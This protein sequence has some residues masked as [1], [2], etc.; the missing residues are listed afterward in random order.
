MHLA[1][2]M[3]RATVGTE[4]DSDLDFEGFFEAEYERLLKTMY[5]LTRNHSEAEDLAQEALAR[6]FGRWDT[7]SAAASPIA[8]VCGVAF[9]MFVIR[10]ER[11]QP[12]PG[13]LEDVPELG[14]RAPCRAVPAGL[15]RGDE[16]C[17][18]E[19]IER[20]LFL[21]GRPRMEQPSAV[22]VG[23]TVPEQL[24]SALETERQALKL[25]QEGIATALDVDDQATREFLAGRLPDEER[26]VDWLETQLFLVE[27][28]GAQLYLSE[29]LGS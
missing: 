5:V 23:A 20:V 25:L 28:L 6:A 13:A 4:R 29:Q 16:G 26:H 24:R 19:I 14:L 12:V 10:A 15:A 7:V 2:G 3:L 9:N 22:T 1:S 17:G 21:D 27:S 18:R 8:C 11:D